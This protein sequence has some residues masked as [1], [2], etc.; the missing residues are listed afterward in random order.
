MIVRVSHKHSIGTGE[1][2][3][4]HEY[5]VGSLLGETNYHHEALL[6]YGNGGTVYLRNDVAENYPT[7][8]WCLSWK[9]RPGLIMTLTQE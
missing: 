1:N 8:F 7:A 6:L 3:Q 5:P 4:P 2:K 9:T